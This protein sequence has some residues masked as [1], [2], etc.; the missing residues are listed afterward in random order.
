[1]QFL[2]KVLDPGYFHR[3]LI[4]QLKMGHMGQRLY[5]L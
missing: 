5:R 4:H 1:L 3:H 2:Q